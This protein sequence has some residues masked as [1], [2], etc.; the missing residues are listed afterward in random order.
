M[1]VFAYDPG[2]ICG[3]LKRQCEGSTGAN[4]DELAAKLSRIAAWEFDRY[5]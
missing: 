2:V 4:W 3:A 1:I 5:R